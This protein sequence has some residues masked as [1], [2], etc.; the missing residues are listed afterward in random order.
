M[1]SPVQTVILCGG[2]G[3][4]L[5]PLSREHFPKQLLRLQGD[6]TMLQATALRLSGS[7]AT[8]SPPLLVG[9]EDYRFLLAEQLRQAGV[10]GA[11]LLLEP[12]GRNTAPALTLAALAASSERT[13]AAAADPILVIMPADHVI[14]DE[15]AFRAAVASACALADAGKL[16]TFGIQPQSPETGYGYIRQGVGVAGGAFEVAEF[17]EKPDLAT[18][19]RYLSGGDYLWNA[20]IFVIKS[21]VW[22]AKIDQCRPDIAQ[23]FCGVSVR[24]D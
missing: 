2:S 19:Q 24:F 8:Q 13:G 4:R 1:S 11:Q 12:V 14:Q 15:P 21:S 10:Q 20:G 3:S 16:V 5:W 9:N 17:V 23:A 18:A 22:L 7:G 6:H